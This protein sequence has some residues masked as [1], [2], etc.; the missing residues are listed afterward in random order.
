[1]L[2]EASA[3][4]ASDMKRPGVGVMVNLVT[5]FN[6][7]KFRAPLEAMHRDRKKIFV[8]TLK[9]DVP[10][11]DGQYEIDQFDTD[12]AIYLVALAPETQRHL[13]SV[14]LL[15]TTGPHLLSEVFPFLC[16]KGV[17]I[18]DDIWEITRLCT[19][20]AKDIEPRLIRRRLATAMCE[21][22]LLYG[23][24]RYT[25]VTHVQYL[26]NLLAVGW[27]CELLGEPR[28]VDRDVVGALSISITPA[29]LQLFR[30]KLG[31]RTPVLQLD[32]F[33]AAA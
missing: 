25:C 31:S 14:R 6:R 7:S 10:V 29:T 12:A 1:M 20:P 19:A 11:V 18:G 13:G 30:E 9:W 5:S 3:C 21:F 32:A 4:D 16:D 15:P 23:I 33:A 26:S 17:P 2:S 24:S 28:Q 22:G 27:E 8:D